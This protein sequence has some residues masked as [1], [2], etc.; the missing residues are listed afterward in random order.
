M[1]TTDSNGILLTD[2][3][4]LEWL[5][6][7]EPRYYQDYC[8]FVVNTDT[9]KCVVG[10]DIHAYAE[11]YLGTDESV[12]YGGNIFFDD[13]YVVYESTLNIPKNIQSKFFQEHGGD[14]RIIKDP[15]LID[16]INSVLLNWVYWE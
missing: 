16:K 10:E 8:K 13:G 12:L 1:P 2:T 6:S 15:L 5:T 7:I 11:R 4:N 14:A 3:V 9:Q